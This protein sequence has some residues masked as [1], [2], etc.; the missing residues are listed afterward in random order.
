MIKSIAQNPL[1]STQRWFIKRSNKIKLSSS[2]LQL[3]HL[4]S[5]NEKVPSR[6]VRS[7]WKWASVKATAF[8]LKSR[9]TVMLSLSLLT[10]AGRHPDAA[11]ILDGVRH[12][13]SNVFVHSWFRC[14]IDLTKM[15]F[16]RKFH[17]NGFIIIYNYI[18]Y[19]NKYKYWKFKTLDS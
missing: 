19:I 10:A 4:S 16:S 8:R 5:L 6:R 7:D 14:L 11:E 3:F 13:R 12:Q 17:T 18:L 9:P 2:S 1:I 15:T